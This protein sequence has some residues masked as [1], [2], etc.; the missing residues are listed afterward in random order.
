MGLSADISLIKLHPEKQPISAS[1]ISSFI[2]ALTVLGTIAFAAIFFYP[3]QPPLS[4]KEDNGIIA[5]VTSAPWVKAGMDFLIPYSLVTGA[6]GGYI[7][8][9]IARDISRHY[10][11]EMNYILIIR[12][13][14]II[15]IVINS[16][17]S[18]LADVIITASCQLAN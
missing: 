8:F 18:S 14:A 1:I 12:L 4:P 11:C 10:E 5:F 9:G 13:M 15:M 3:L 2:L 7:G 17:R 6:L 16:L